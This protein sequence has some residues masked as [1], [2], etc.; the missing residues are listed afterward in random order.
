MRQLGEVCNINTD[1]EF[2]S[3][4]INV[5]EKIIMFM[6]V[7]HKTHSFDNGRHTICCGLTSIFWISK[8]VEGKYCSQQLVHKE[9]SELGKMVSLML[10]MC[11][12]IFG[13]GKAVVFDS[14]F[15]VD[16]GITELE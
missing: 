2:N 13:T 10:R 1:D 7:G 4:W 16:K 11:K 15:C 12:N 5:L 14:G 6:C 8:I 9:Y 3:S